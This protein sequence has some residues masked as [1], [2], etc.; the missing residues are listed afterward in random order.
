MFS[1]S[2]FFFLSLGSIASLVLIFICLKSFFISKRQ[3][4]ARAPM[5]AF[6]AKMFY[7]LKTALPHH[8]ILAQVAFSALI[9]NDHLKIRRK[10]NRKVTDFVILNE[11]LDVIAIVEL[12]DPSHLEKMQEDQ[13]RD[14]MLKEAG[15]DVFRYTEIPNI[16][17][18]Q[19]DIL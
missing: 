12:D 10:F 17:Q 16:R 18:L 11:T 4:F 7:R 3:F 14:K 1:S 2:Q 5:T 15:Y 19:K 8:H 13:L 9:T 6:E